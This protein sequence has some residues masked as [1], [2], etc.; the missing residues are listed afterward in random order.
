MHLK[1]C[2]L[3]LGLSLTVLLDLL[4]LMETICLV[5]KVLMQVDKYL[6]NIKTLIQ[7]FLQEVNLLQIYYLILELE[8]DIWLLE[9]L[10]LVVMEV[11][12]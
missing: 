2:I 3:K 12:I 6:H 11:L 7:K 1:R 10:S 9:R 5:N 8:L 4:Y